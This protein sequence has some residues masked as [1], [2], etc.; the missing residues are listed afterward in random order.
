MSN[1][2]RSIAVLVCL[3]S[4]A[5]AS[6]GSPGSDRILVSLFDYE[7]GRRFELAS[8]SHTDRV[9]YYSTVR[10]DA[11]RKIQLDA[12]MRQLIGELNG[13]ELAEHAQEG[14]APSR[15]GGAISRAFEIRTGERTRHWVVG[16]GTP[17]AERLAFNDCVHSFLQLYNSSASFQAVHNDEGASFFHRPEPSAAKKR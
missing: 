6:T 8:E 13:H 5:C 12:V 17:A 15:G 14:P 9:E 2:L 3:L 11:A 10:D 16:S 4:G 1:A 7:S